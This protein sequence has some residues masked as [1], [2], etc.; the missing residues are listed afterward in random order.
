MLV[1]EDTPVSADMAAQLADL[2]LP[3]LETLYLTRSELTAAA[4]PELARADWPSLS[5]LH[6]SHDDIDAVAVLLRLDLEM[7]QALKSYACSSL[8]VQRTDAGPD[9]G[10]WLNLNRIRVS[11]LYVQLTTLRVHNLSNHHW[12]NLNL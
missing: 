6:L 4:V 12:C 7:V 8:D 5:H 1:I 10:L 3:N 9:L 2:Q 11:R